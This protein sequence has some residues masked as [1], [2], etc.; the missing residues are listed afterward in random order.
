MKSSTKSTPGVGPRN[1][2]RRKQKMRDGLEN[3]DQAA[4]GDGTYEPEHQCRGA[5]P[6][7]YP[8]THPCLSMYLWSQMK[9][10]LM[11]VANLSEEKSLCVSQK[12]LPCFMF[13]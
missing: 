1:M 5:G 2:K 7:T 11:M 3:P 12:Q 6:S 8:H 10:L 4:E 9:S 13:L